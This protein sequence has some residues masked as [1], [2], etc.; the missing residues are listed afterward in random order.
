MTDHAEA[1]E[2]VLQPAGGAPPTSAWRRGTAVAPTESG[3]PRRTEQ[4]HRGPE[5]EAEPREGTAPPRFL[6]PHV[7]E[8]LDHLRSPQSS[9]PAWQRQRQ[10]AV[11]SHDNARQ[12]EWAR[13]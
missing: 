11:D 8:Q 10:Q 2:D 7:L 4:S 1:V 3:L 5:R 13:R 9:E 6:Q 12:P